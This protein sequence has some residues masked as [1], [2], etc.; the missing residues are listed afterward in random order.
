MSTQRQSGFSLLEMALSLAVLG[1]LFAMVPMALNALNSTQSA[2]PALDR[3]KLAVNAAVG[4]I[5]QHDRL[6][7]PDTDEDGLENCDG[8][9]SGRFPF[10][11]VGLGQ[12]LVNESGFPFHYAVYQHTNANLATPEPELQS[13][14]EPLLLRGDVSAQKNALDFCQG[15]RLGVS[16]GL[17]TTEPHVQSHTGERGINPAFLLVDPGPLDADRDGRP[18]DGLNATGLEYESAGR[19]Q[20]DEY[21]DRVIAMSFAELATR[22]DCPAILARVS[23]ATREANAAYDAWR[24]YTFY[25]D[26]RQFGYEVRVTNLAIANFKR[27]VAEFNSA[28]STA[29]ALNDLATGLASASGAGGVAVA[30]INA[31]AAGF[32]IVDELESTAEDVDE[33][34]DQLATAVEQLKAANNALDDAKDYRDQATQLALARDARGWFQ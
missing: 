14:Y 13:S 30:A 31:T 3:A 10:R 24:A 11:T 1:F 7:C 9:R 4:F 26:F 15:L 32:M 12:P 28:A 25:R 20:S 29:M 5:V 18:F 8:S 34:T 6:P 27:Q 23:A 17:Q 21:D 2:A 22:L 19:G 33:K 16:G